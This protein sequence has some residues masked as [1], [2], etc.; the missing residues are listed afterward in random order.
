MCSFID[1]II[2]NLAHIPSNLD[3][4]TIL[5][6]SARARALI[7]FLARPRLSLRL[8]LSMMTGLIENE[9]SL[10]VTTNESAIHDGASADCQNSLRHEVQE[11]EVE[12]VQG[13]A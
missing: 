2:H 11:Y 8:S 5:F 12:A 7:H 3:R 4:P 10:R 6:A 9:H 1:C 13:Y